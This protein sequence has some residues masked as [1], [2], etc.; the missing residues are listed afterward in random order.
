MILLLTCDEE[1][2][3]LDGRQLVEEEARRATQALV[4]EPPAPGGQVKTARKGAGMWK[5][6]AH[7]IAAHAG[8]NPEA[9]ASAILELARQTERLHAVN[10]LAS[11]TSFNV[12]VVR[13]DTKQR[14][15]GER[16]DRTRCSLQLHERSSACQ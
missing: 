8:L 10:E 2:G 5:V 4:L 16:G 11:G 13:G 14:G 7:G 1:T 6:T 9:G 12:G 15:S 3:S